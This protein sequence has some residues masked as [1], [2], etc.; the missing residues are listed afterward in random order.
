MS[1]QH[2]LKRQG[3][4]LF[5]HRSF[6]PLIMLA[7]AIQIYFELYLKHNQ[8][9]TNHQVLGAGYEILCFV[10]SMAGLLVR[11]YTVG[12]TPRNTSGRNTEGQLADTL[13]TTGAYSIIRHPL[14]FGN[15]LCWL[16]IALMTQHTWF[17]VLFCLGYWIYY[18]R[19]MY[20]EEFF[21]TQKMGTVYE[22][23]SE[24]TPAFWP[25]GSKFIRPSISF[26]W[27]KVL[28]KEKNG[29]VAIMVVF[30]FLHIS[31]VSILG[32][33]YFNWIVI[34]AALASLL[35]YLILKYIKKNT[36]LLNEEGR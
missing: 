18:E 31:K 24:K 3:D 12:H 7:L 4:W 23:W 14:Y 16:G 36:G 33:E 27:K 19:I 1:L 15:F 29:F 10:V 35:I 20:A 34:A 9:S 22:E 30:A 6:L 8:D 25:F 21:L 32:T 28:K 26:S 5:K 11:I 17:V 13:N 2:E